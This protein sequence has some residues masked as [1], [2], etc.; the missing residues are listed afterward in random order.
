MKKFYVAMVAASLLLGI[1]VEHGFAQS[2]VVKK[3]EAGP[4][5]GSKVDDFVLKDSDGKKQK[6]SGMLNKGPVAIV[7]FRSAD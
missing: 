1:F 2:A 3:V 6:L 5:V 7:F 4:K